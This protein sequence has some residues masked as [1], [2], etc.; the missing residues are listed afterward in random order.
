MTSSRRGVHSR[1]VPDARLLFSV[2]PALA[3]SASQASFHVVA[4]RGRLL[5][6]IVCDVPRGLQPYAGQERPR[7]SWSIGPSGQ[8]VVRQPLRTSTWQTPSATPETARP[9]GWGPSRGAISTPRRFE[10][11]S[12]LEVP[13]FVH[14]AELPWN[15]PNRNLLLSCLGLLVDNTWPPQILGLMAGG[16]SSCFRRPLNSEGHV[17]S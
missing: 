5:P 7:S 12:N 4:A 15:P 13:R 8:P 11:I 10:Q 17:E 3:W 6:S 16:A 1:H 2:F 9:E 14:L